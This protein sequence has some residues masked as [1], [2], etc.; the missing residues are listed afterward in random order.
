LPSA[1][2]ML[3]VGAFPLAEDTAPRQERLSYLRRLV[4]NGSP[5]GQ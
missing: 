1:Y 3:L 4:E 2:V 5:F